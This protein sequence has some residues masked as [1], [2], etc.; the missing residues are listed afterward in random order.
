MVKAEIRERSVKAASRR[1]DIEFEDFEKPGFPSWIVSG[2]AFAGGA[3]YR[4]APDLPLAAYRGEGVA[5]SYRNGSDTFVGSLTSRKFRMPRRWLHVR[6]AGRGGNL[7]RTRLSDVRLTLVADSYKSKAF[8]PTG[9]DS[10]EWQ[11]AQMTTQ[12]DRL[13]YFE[14]VDRSREGHIIV[15]RIVLSDSKEP[16]GDG[17]RR[18]ESLLPAGA[19]GHP[20]VRRPGGRVPEAVRH[21]GEPTASPIA[22]PIRSFAGPCILSRAGSRRPVILPETERVR[23]RKL[24]RDRAYVGK[25]DP[26]VVVRDEQPRRGLHTTSEIHLRG[27]HKNLGKEVPRGVLACH[28]VTARPAKRATAAAGCMSRGNL[29]GPKTLFPRE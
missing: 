7:V 19:K 22:A 29:P 1:N 12:F 26:G 14:L 16:P 2:Q 15:D 27:N 3:R 20:I 13:C 17:P 24:Q 5:D 4:P 18:C 25:V 9:A 21:R 10:F 11:S 28:L 8:V 6:L 23:L